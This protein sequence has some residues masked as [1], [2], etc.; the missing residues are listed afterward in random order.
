MSPA[1][2]RAALGGTLALLL[3][4][5]AAYAFLCDDAFI[6][7][8]YAR[9]LADGFGLAFNPGFERVEGYTNFLWVVIL[10]AGD[11]LGIDPAQS[12]I[13]L[14]LLLT[15]G[16]WAL[17]ARGG[18]RL[19][20]TSAG[21]W[22]AVVAPLLLASSR[23]IAVWSTSG[24]E[25]RLFEVLI[26]GAVLRVAHELE[27]P[28]SRP[29]GAFLFA[30]A[31]LTRPDGLLVAAS[32]LTVAAATGV[33]RRTFSLPGIA[34]QAGVFWVIVGA[35]MLWRKSYYGAWLP[36]TYY[37]KVG[38][39]TWWDMGAAYLGS[40]ALEYGFLLLLP[41][42]VAGVVRWVRSGYTHVALVFGAAVIP[43]ALYIASIG[44][45]H[46]EYR[47]LDV[48]L[49]FL[50]LAA[51]AGV[52]G[53]LARS[54]AVGAVFLGAL[55][56][57]GTWL[58]WQTHRQFVR[59]YYPGFPGLGLVLED[60]RRFLD[61]AYDPLYG[62][63]LLRSLA[64]AH[65]ELVRKTTSRFVG[66][67]QEEH[68]LFRASVERQASVLKERID[69]GVIA[70]DVRMALSC[71][72]VIPYRTGVFTLDRLGLTDA[73][74]ARSE[75]T[76]ERVMAHDKHATLDYAR[77]RGVDFW[78][79]DPVHPAIHVSD[80]QLL[81]YLQR[82]AADEDE[83]FLGDAGDGWFLVGIFP[84]GYDAARA[85]FP[86]IAF[87]TSRDAETIGEAYEAVL[88]HRRA[89]L[90][91]DPSDVAAAVDLS[92]AL[93]AL[94]RSEEAIRLLER[95][96]PAHPE[97]AYN[98]GTVL[99]KAGRF[100]EAVVALR[101]SVTARPTYA[102]AHF[103]LGLALYRAGDSAAA[104]SEFREAVRLDPLFWEARYALAV[105][106]LSAGD[107]GCLDE[108][109]RALMESGDPAFQAKARRLEGAGR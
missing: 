20:P 55:L 18:A 58:P 84:S 36:N 103:N 95:F 39:R 98:L 40:F 104:P 87:R 76:G 28:R 93:A 97:V 96:D 53:L 90:E 109:L 10:A 77:E 6:S 13:P 37:A 85:R 88:A 45:D 38:G 107:A 60:Q 26:V 74:V 68:A 9:N 52:A 44:G 73:V 91:R 35:H 57:A 54:R 75:P 31:T 34:L 4:H 99:A 86:G 24:L 61:P 82:V 16:L 62:L 94:G 41:L 22:A 42:V 23:S 49:P 59:E 81:W 1:L 46:F 78:P 64:L 102:A 89:A 25:T 17:V 3:A 65:R 43:H 101:R 67:R 108:Q 51:G 8:R 105:S 66:I 15:V 100:Q 12:A 27:R 7:F 56:V 63:P 47:P 2:R 69:G 11:R 19:T 50:F 21:P 106:C 79:A 33:R 14:S 5:A 48:Y 71:V 72:G 80:P 29:W 70:P 30:L 32:V 83:I 92:V